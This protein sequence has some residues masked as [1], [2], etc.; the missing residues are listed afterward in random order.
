VRR[1]AVAG[2]AAAGLWA[3]CEPLARRVFRTGFSDLRLLGAPLAA[4][5]RWRGVGLTVHVINGA[6][7]GAVFE[8]LGASGPRRGMAAALAEHLL[9]W[10]MMAV[11][12]RLHPDRRDGTWPPLL[13]D[14]RVFAQETA[15]HLVFGA[16]LGQLL[17]SPGRPDRGAAPQGLRSAS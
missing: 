4:G 1:G 5:R 15:L 12:D 3:A 14:R 11:A 17:S 16:A 6:V 9:T 13:G 8:R 7:F 10:P 2:A